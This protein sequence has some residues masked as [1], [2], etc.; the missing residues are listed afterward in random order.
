MVLFIHRPEYYGFNEDEEGNS[1]VGL[2][3]II[4]AKHRNGAVGDIR[5]RFRKEQAKFSDLDDMEFAPFAAPGVSQALTFGS[6]MNEDPL[7]ASSGDP[8]FDFLKEPL[9]D[10][11]IPY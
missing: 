9:S 11:E 2:A 4:V 5:L 10:D 3:E 6:K 8:D 7:P 1:L